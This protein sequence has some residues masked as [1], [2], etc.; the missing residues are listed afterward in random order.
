MDGQCERGGVTLKKKAGPAKPPKGRSGPLQNEK[1][2]LE[3]VVKLANDMKVETSR[4]FETQR[5]AR[6]GG[7]GNGLYLDSRKRCGGAAEVGLSCVG[8]LGVVV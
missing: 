6:L 2:K 1:R 7:G 4:I 8:V 3:M 5:R